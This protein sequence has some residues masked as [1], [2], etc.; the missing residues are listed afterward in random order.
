MSAQFCIFDI[1][2]E[3]E[4]NGKRKRFA[5]KQ[6]IPYFIKKCYLRIVC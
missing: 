4:A 6:I 5:S 1:K 3:N 2:D